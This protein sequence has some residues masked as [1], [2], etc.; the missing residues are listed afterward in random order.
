MTKERIVSIVKEGI[1]EI[2]PDVSEEKIDIEQS[3]RDY[4][5]N[6]ID[7]ADIVIR[8]MEMLKLKIPMMEFANIKN[9]E[10]IVD[11]LYRRANP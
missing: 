7:R 6:S 9:I 3:L 2:L 11:L 1:V 10:G 5:A 8:A 4:G